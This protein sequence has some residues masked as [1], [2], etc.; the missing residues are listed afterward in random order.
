MM[1]DVHC[2]RTTWQF[3][4]MFLHCNRLLFSHQ[5]VSDS[6]TSWTATCQASLSFTMSQ[7][8]LKLMSFD[9]VMPSNYLILCHLLLLLPSIFP[10]I[11]VS[12]FILM[13]NCAVS[14]F[15]IQKDCLS[16]LIIQE[17][18][19]ASLLFRAKFKTS[20]K[21]SYFCLLFIAKTIAGLKT[22][23]HA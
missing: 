18:E 15:Q 14:K 22:A 16:C 12:A 9:Q 17:Q 3:L 4:G 10:S 1:K 6:A 8:L 21:L 13:L 23:R 20:L 5:V 11:R 7:S 2:T 19:D